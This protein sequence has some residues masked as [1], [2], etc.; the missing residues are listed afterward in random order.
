[1]IIITPDIIGNK[2]L[3]LIHAISWNDR[4]ILHLRSSVYKESEIES[5][6]RDMDSS[7]YPFIAIHNYPQLVKKHV[8][9]N[10]IHLSERHT[11]WITDIPED[12]TWTISTAVH[13]IHTFNRLHRRFSYAFIS[14][15]FPSI[16]KKDYKQTLDFKMDNIKE[17]TN[18][19]TKLI[20]LGGIHSQN[21]QEL[22]TMGY[23][24]VALCGYI[25]QTQAPSIALER[26][27]FAQSVLENAND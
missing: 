15:V 19:N 9:L 14:P 18:D 22:I 6:L 24:D 8:L 11:E 13:D 10:R 23:D 17:R 5:I 27:R 16:S 1:M 3:E 21:I 2:E 4:L 7:I 12:T 20:A 26:V 25:W